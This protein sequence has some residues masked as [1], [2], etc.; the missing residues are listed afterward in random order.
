MNR[1]DERIA[2]SNVKRDANGNLK[3]KSNKV[4]DRNGPLGNKRSADD[5][6]NEQQRQKAKTLAALAP[7]KLDPYV[8]LQ[9]R[10]NELQDDADAQDAAK[11]ISLVNANG[12]L[13]KS[14]DAVDHL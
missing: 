12:N 9:N 4:I 13:V 14:V 11:D 10:V 5:L 3:L 2:K 8:N 6:V 1:E 7:K